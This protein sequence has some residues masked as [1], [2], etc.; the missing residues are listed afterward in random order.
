[1]VIF[2]LIYY[3]KIPSLD[4]PYIIEVTLYMSKG[5][6]FIVMFFVYPMYIEDKIIDKEDE[7]QDKK[8]E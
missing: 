2:E 5:F 3:W 6:F 4:I 1:M 7:R 8:E